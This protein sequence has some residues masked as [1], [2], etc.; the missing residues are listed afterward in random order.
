M[1][2]QKEMNWNPLKR[3]ALF[4]SRFLSDALSNQIGEKICGVTYMWFTEPCWGCV[5]KFVINDVRTRDPEDD[6][7]L[8][9]NKSK[10]LAFTDSYLFNGS[11]SKCW[12]ESYSNDITVSWALKIQTW[13]QKHDSTPFYFPYFAFLRLD[14]S[15]NNLEELLCL[16]IPDFLALIGYWYV[17]QVPIRFLQATSHPDGFHLSLFREEVFLEP[18]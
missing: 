15:Y 18:H 16:I 7:L 14:L 10:T 12:N 5:F 8:A 13:I 1:L 11:P 2:D 17:W 6:Q 9:K 4:H 3:M